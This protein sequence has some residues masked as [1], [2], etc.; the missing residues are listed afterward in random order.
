MELPQWNCHNGIA[1]MEL[2]QWNC[3]NGI[4]TMELPQWNCGVRAPAHHVQLMGRATRLA[5]VYSIL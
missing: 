4:G 3:H 5:T 2:P 1:T